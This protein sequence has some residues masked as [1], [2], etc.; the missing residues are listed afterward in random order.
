M[1]KIVPLKTNTTISRIGVL[2]KQSKQLGDLYALRKFLRNQEIRDKNISVDQ[3]TMAVY[4]D[5]VTKNKVE[6]IVKRYERGLSEAGHGGYRIAF[7]I[8]EE[9][10]DLL[11]ILKEKSKGLHD[12]EISSINE[13]HTKEQKAWSKERKSLEKKARNQELING[14]IF[15]NITKLEYK[16][17]KLKRKLNTYQISIL[18]I[19]WRRLKK[20]VT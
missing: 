12:A 20:L 13:R 19:A 7:E 10:E 2:V 1:S 14:V 9:E 4:I 11:N 8:I 3:K 17:K 6:N 18:R 16:N 5:D 15:K